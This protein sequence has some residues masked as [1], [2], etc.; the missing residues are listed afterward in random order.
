VVRIDGLFLFV[1]IARLKYSAPIKVV[2]EV[3]GLLSRRLDS[4]AHV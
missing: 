3:S 1:M 4:G 2:R